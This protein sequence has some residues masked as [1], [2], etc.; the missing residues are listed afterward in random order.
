MAGTL[1]TGS[2]DYVVTCDCL[3]F[4]SF[5]IQDLIFPMVTLLVDCGI[6]FA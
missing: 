4:L 6:F 1:Q 2:S 5:F 3:K